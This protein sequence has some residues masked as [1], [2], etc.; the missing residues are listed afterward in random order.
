M[1]SFQSNLHCTPSGTPERSIGENVDE[2]SKNKLFDALNGNI[3]TTN[4]L[5]SKVDDL[6]NTSVTAFKVPCLAK[7]NKKALPP[8]SNLDL[9]NL[10]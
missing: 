10:K 2:V 4:E 9:S 7:R 1:D 8:W 5:N 6:E 3:G